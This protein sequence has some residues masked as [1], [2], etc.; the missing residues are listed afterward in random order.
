MVT[1]AHARYE[2]VP[3]DYVLKRRVRTA[4]RRPRSEAGSEADQQGEQG[5]EQKVG[6][7]ARGSSAMNDFDLN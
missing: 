4:S 3:K 5:S 1:I 7:V 6:T 2:G